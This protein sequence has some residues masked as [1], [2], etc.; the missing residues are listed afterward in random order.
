[1]A[2]EAR[3]VGIVDPFEVRVFA[4]RL[5]AEGDPTLH[6]WAKYVL[7]GPEDITG[8][9]TVS[10]VSITAHWYADRESELQG[11]VVCGLAL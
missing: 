1:M 4:A 10:M 9:Q 2:S 11:H 7:N 8:R 6:N 5:L 3:S